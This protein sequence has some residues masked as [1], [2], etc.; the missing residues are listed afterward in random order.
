MI[1]Q[2]IYRSRRHRIR[3]DFAIAGLIFLCF[4][5]GVGIVAVTFGF[6]LMGGFR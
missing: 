6:A 1:T 4:L 5:A 2:R 3:H